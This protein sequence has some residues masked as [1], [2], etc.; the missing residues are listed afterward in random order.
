LELAELFF[1]SLME[2]CLSAAKRVLAI[3]WHQ[4]YMFRMF[5]VCRLMDENTHFFHASVSTWLCRNHITILHDSGTPVNSRRGKERIL[6]CFYSGL[7]EVEG[8]PRL[9]T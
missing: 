6:H 3:Y 5:R 7:L 2:V 8:P 4:C 1:R 9:V